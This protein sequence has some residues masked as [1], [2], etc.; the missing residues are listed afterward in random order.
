MAFAAHGV[1]QE[2]KK[3]FLTVAALPPNLQSETND[4]LTNSETKTFVVLKEYILKTTAIPDQIRI[5]KLLKDSP[6]T[7]K[8]PSVYLRYLRETAGN[9][10]DRNSSFIRSIFLERIPSNISMILAPSSGEPLDTLAEM[11]DRVFLQMQSPASVGCISSLNPDAAPYTQQ[12][13]SND[14][15]ILSS[16]NTIM[17]DN[18][19][20][21]DQ[22]RSTISNMQ[23]QIQTHNANTMSTVTSLQQNLESLRRQ[24]DSNSYNRSRSRSNSSNRYT[25]SNGFGNSLCFYH[26]KFQDRAQKCVKPCSWSGPLPKNG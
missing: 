22:L 4:F 25:S 14:S 6:I 2:Q 18:R 23:Q 7:D 24:V 17:M 11:A 3:T 16:I 1:T 26:S 20:S 10:I 15:S 13:L 8:K 12:N 9:G 5:Q 21:L 19:S